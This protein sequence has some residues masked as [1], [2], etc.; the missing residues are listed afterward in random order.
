[1]NNFYKIFEENNNLNIFLGENCNKLINLD[2][3]SHIVE[4]FYKLKGNNIFNIKTNDDFLEINQNLLNNVL[5]SKNDIISA[6][7]E[8]FLNQDGINLSL[9]HNIVNSKIFKSIFSLNYDNIFEYNFKDFLYCYEPF[10][11]VKIDHP[12]IS[13]FKVFGDLEKQKVIITTQDLKK[14]ITLDRYKPFIN[15]VQSELKKRQTIILGVDLNKKNIQN[16]FKIILDSIL[17]EYETIY[18]VSDQNLDMDTLE[19]TRYYNIELI[20]MSIND[21]NSLICDDKSFC[22]EDEKISS[23]E[24][25]ETLQE[26]D[27]VEIVDKK[28]ENKIIRINKNEDF[29]VTNEEKMI[30]NLISSN[31]TSGRNIS[32]NKFPKIITNTGKADVKIGDKSI[33][34]LSVRILNY[35]DFT[36]LELKR[37]DFRVAVE[38]RSKNNKDEKEEFYEYEIYS[39]LKNSNLIEVFNILVSIFSSEEISINNKDYMIK[40]HIEN[41]KEKIKLLE[42]LILLEMYDYIIDKCSISNALNFFDIID[43]S[44]SIY[45]LYQLFFNKDIITHVDLNIVNKHNIEE[46]EKPIFYRVHSLKLSNLNFNISEK[47]FLLDEISNDELIS[48]NI[49]LENKEVKIELGLEDF[50]ESV[51]NIG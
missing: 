33:N 17:Y 8:N 37:V 24:K 48:N 51:E 4:N 47:I 19:F 14:F 18:L 32:K 38:I 21:F 50:A 15:E 27:V 39:N 40:T 22:E 7:E 20:P 36:L 12:L 42:I 3:P 46:K 26:K 29:F 49:V 35:G 10:H 45:L 28:E 2:M 43:K 34:D 11:F 30:K 44:Y 41:D 23:E 31:F 25:D 5:Y 13:L 6:F 9:Y 16:L 1:M